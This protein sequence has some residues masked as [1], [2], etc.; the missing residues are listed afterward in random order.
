LFANPTAIEEIEQPVSAANHGFAISV[1]VISK[2]EAG[3]EV[4]FVGID[5]TSGPAGG[6]RDHES[7]I[8]RIKVGLVVVDL[9]R[10]GIHV[11]ADAKI[12]REA[13]R[14]SPIILREIAS[15]PAASLV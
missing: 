2:A 13:V 8:C 6:A 7:A 3:R 14:R 10:P 11:V 15:F 5:Q 9:V 12:K 1:Q 4:C